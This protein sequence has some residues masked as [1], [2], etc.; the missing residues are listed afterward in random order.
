[1]LT[2]L[3]TSSN[4]GLKK[5]EKTIVYFEKFT[6]LPYKRRKFI[7]AKFVFHESLCTQ[8]NLKYSSAKVNVHEKKKFCG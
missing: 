2:L 3:L 7:H 6:Q 8:K 4:F 5:T 1:M